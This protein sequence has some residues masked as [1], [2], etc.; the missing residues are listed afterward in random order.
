[1]FGL[2]VGVA[3]REP[4]TLGGVM[5]RVIDGKN[6]FQKKRELNE[7]LQENPQYRE[8]Y[9]KIE[10][11]LPKDAD[12]RLSMLKQIRERHMQMLGGVFQNLRNASKELSENLQK[13]AEVLEERKAQLQKLQKVSSENS[14]EID[15]N[16]KD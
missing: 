2:Q 3:D 15:K 13:L 1:M 9:L 4:I 14:D 12:Q 16:S 6:L 8:L 10:D 7:F 5:G 11:K